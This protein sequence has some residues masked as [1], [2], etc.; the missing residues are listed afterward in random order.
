[1]SDFDEIFQLIKYDPHS[2]DVL[3]DSISEIS[4]ILNQDTDGAAQLMKRVLDYY[5]YRITA[6]PAD[7]PHEIFMIVAMIAQPFRIPFMVEHHFIFK[8]PAGQQIE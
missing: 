4:A 6:L 8:H 1:M 3:P 2:S 5:H 7:I